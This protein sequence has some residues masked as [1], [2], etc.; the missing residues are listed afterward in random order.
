MPWKTM[1]SQVKQTE[2]D[3][4]LTGQTEA[5]PKEPRNSNMVS[6][7]DLL[8]KA[9]EELQMQEAPRTKDEDGRASH[10]TP[11]SLLNC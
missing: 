2:Q 9:N 8:Q 6:L 4:Y 11:L 5:S 10:C 7:E 3:I 1:G